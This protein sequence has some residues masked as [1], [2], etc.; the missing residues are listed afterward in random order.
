MNISEVSRAGPTTVG[1]E[2]DFASIQRPGPPQTGLTVTRWADIFL[3]DHLR[4]LFISSYLPDSVVGLQINIGAEVM[5]VVVQRV[6]LTF[7]I[8]GPFSYQHRCYKVGLLTYSLPRISIR[9]DSDAS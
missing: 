5:A 3:F 8:Y 9:V 1:T 7:F 4:L 2:H 6:F